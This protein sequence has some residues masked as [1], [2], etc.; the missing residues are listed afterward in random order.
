[1]TLTSIY[2]ALADLAAQGDTTEYIARYLERN[3]Y[4]GEPG[5]TCKCPLA[6][7]LL[8]R[9]GMACDV[10]P[11]PGGAGA[12]HCGARIYPLPSVL[13]DLALEFDDGKFPALVQERK[14]S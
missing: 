5:E 1:M 4:V 3:S 11:W 8:D 7:F 14:V 12:V 13:N 6:V 9:T 2:G 10:D